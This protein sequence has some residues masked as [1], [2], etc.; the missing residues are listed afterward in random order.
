MAACSRAFHRTQ[1][2]HMPRQ[3]EQVRMWTPLQVSVNNMMLKLAA[4]LAVWYVSVSVAEGSTWSIEGFSVSLYSCR[5][6]KSSLYWLSAALALPAH[7]RCGQGTKAT[8][9]EALLIL[10]RRLSYPIRWCDLR[11][12]FGR[13]EPELSPIFNMVRI[14]SCS[15]LPVC[16]VATPIINIFCRLWMICFSVLKPDWHH[17]IWYGW[18]R[19][20]FLMPFMQKVQH[21]TIAGGLLMEPLALLLVQC[22]IK[23][24]CSVAVKES[25]ASSFRWQLPITRNLITV[26]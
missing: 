4:L 23:V 1:A 19:V 10:L 13:E 26:L 11:Q 5:F 7:Y 9:M 17:L 8:G 6:D 14:I 18:T 2:L 21:C 3:N 16:N 22:G 12:L 15:N 25:T 24:Y 20:H